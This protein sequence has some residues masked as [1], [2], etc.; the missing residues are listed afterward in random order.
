MV[1]LRKFLYLDSQIIDTYL[2][3]VDGGVSAGPTSIK[4][5]EERTKEGKG[6]VSLSP[7]QIGGGIA[8]RS[9]TEFQRSVVETSAARFERLYQSVSPDELKYV[10]IANEDLWDSLRRTTVVEVVG[11]IRLLQWQQILE[12]A[13]QI[14][15]LAE[16]MEQ[17]GQ[18]V[19]AQTKAMLAG[20]KQLGT[21]NEGK[22]T[23]IVLDVLESP[24]YRFVATL[25]DPMILVPRAELEGEATIIGSI[26]RK[27]KPGEKLT[28]SSLLTS[29]SA[30]TQLNRAQRRASKP[31]AM[32]G[33]NPLFEEVAAPACILTPV[34]VFK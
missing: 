30:M 5:T 15:P 14:S 33:P 22:G 6:G 17:F 23:T 12:F 9:T 18:S 4:E 11:R 21:M 16:M 27:L 26:Q 28:V 3:S 1:A 2:S 24:E 13:D 7:I 31:K 32:A 19:D 29:T 34:A 20:I 10:E 8:D 25:S